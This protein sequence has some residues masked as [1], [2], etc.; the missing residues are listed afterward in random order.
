MTSHVQQRQI[1]NEH[2]KISPIFLAPSV[3]QEEQCSIEV[4]T[5]SQF[6]VL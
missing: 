5:L 1:N 3:L 6:S 4:L 2:E